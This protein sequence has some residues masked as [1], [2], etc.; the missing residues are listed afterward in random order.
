[1]DPRQRRTRLRSEESPSTLLGCAKTR[2]RAPRELRLIVHLPSV[3]VCWC[4]EAG[5]T[6]PHG[7]CLPRRLT[8]SRQITK[9][10][11]MHT[12][13]TN[14]RNASR[15][16]PNPISQEVMKQDPWICNTPGNSRKVSCPEL[17]QGLVHAREP[18]NMTPFQV[19]DARGSCVSAYIVA[20]FQVMYERGSDAYTYIVARSQVHSRLRG[21]MH[22]TI[23]IEQVRRRSIGRFKTLNALHILRKSCICCLHH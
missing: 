11:L 13:R 3:R 6:H 23:S 9:S 19:V 17:R 1:M 8:R 22:L 21:I 7:C 14:N 20:P 15:R 18:N 12:F 16:A 5:G 4:L 2:S 10:P